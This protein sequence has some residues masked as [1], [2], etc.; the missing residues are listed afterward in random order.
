MQTLARLFGRSPFSAL[1][2][3]MEKVAKSVLGLEPLFEAVK[4]K[5]FQAVEKQ[6]NLISSFEHEADLS[7]NEIRA[8]LSSGLFLPVSRSSLLE[9]L[10]FQ[11]DLADH[12][13]NVGVLLS[14]KTLELSPDVLQLLFVLVKK[15]IEAFTAVSAI[16][17]EMEPLFESS[18]GGH[19]AEK[20]D[21][22]IEKVGLLEHE[23]D[24]FQRTLLKKYFSENNQDPSSVYLWMRIIH[25]VSSISDKAEGLA[26]K[27]RMLLE[28][29]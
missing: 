12:A 14:L 22:M 18:F 16:I 19:E 4:D 9:L 2:A 27:V 23:S 29:K 1:K 13:Q 6:A 21:K 7:K 17:Y 8:H 28:V 15:N 25:E 3:H 26:N 10:T 11:D 24:L 20:V 5:N